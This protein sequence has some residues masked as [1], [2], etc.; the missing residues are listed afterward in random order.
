M[1]FVLFHE[2][3]PMWLKKIRIKR[4][5]EWVIFEDLEEYIKWAHLFIDPIEN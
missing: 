1:R 4:E 5:C 2:M 3:R